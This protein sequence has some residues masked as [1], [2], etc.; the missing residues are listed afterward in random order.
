MLG[1]SGPR[2]RPGGPYVE[3]IWAKF[4]PGGPYLRWICASG[5]QGSKSPG[6]PITR[7]K[8]KNIYI[9]M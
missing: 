5:G 3:W 1:G 6:F 2:L 4:G 9:Y 8:K 7:K